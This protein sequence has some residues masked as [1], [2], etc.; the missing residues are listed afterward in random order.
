MTLDHST[1]D[2]SGEVVKGSFSGQRLDDMEEK[3]LDKLFDECGVDESSMQLLQSYLD[4]RFGPNWHE[5]FR[6]SNSPWGSENHDMGPEEAYKVLGLA[7]NASEADIKE[8]H[9]KLMASNHPDHGGSSY[10]ATKI[11]RARD[12]LLKK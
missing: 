3:L 11:N 10:L 1:G 9:R 7:P 5:N 8:T 6:K 12:V 2:L 4:R